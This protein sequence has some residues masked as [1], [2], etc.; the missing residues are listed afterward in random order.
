MDFINSF[1]RQ[2]CCLALLI[3]NMP[4]NLLVTYAETAKLPA[5]KTANRLLIKIR[6]Q[7]KFR[8]VDN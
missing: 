7:I 3:K 8:Q 1:L 4:F 2:R 6:R 5:Y